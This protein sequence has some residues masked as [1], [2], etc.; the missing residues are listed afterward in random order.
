MQCDA[1]DVNTLWLV[2]PPRPK[3]A[4]AVGPGVG[5]GNPPGFAVAEQ[6]FIHTEVCVH[7][8]LPL[9]AGL[10]GSS[11]C[12]NGLGGFLGMCLDTSNEIIGIGIIRVGR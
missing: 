6:S 2:G 1:K 5:G 8:L 7:T 10:V 12:C 9:V 3:K 11:C 4:T